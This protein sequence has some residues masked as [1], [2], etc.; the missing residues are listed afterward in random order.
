MDH[1]RA[2]LDV[3]YPLWGSAH[4]ID[5]LQGVAH[6]ASRRITVL[7]CILLCP[8]RSF[9]RLR[10]AKYVAWSGVRRGC[11]YGCP[12]DAAI[13]PIAV[14]RRN[15]LRPGECRC[16]NFPV[17]SYACAEQLPSSYTPPAPIQ[18]TPVMPKDDVGPHAANSD[19]ARSGAMVIETAGG[20]LETVW[21]ARGHQCRLLSRLRARSSTAPPSTDRNARS[22]LESRQLCPWTSHRRRWVLQTLALQVQRWPPTHRRRL[23]LAQRRT[24]TARETTCI[25]DCTHGCF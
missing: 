9:H 21:L 16:E 6:V 13:T 23:T 25:P 14:L 22:V 12:S 1:L 8:P 20:P 18:T 10:S 7:R 11:R 3:V 15:W 5:V 17:E 24:A 2:V 19:A 4:P